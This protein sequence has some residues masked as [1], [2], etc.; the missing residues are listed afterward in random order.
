M[1]YCL[2]PNSPSGRGTPAEGD[3]ID[4]REGPFQQ[5]SEKMNELSFLFL[6]PFFPQCPDHSLK[7]KIKYLLGISAV[8]KVADCLASSVSNR[9]IKFSSFI[10]GGG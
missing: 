3:G 10:M 8:F 4:Q 2:S 9:T 5:H 7:N 1:I 6:F